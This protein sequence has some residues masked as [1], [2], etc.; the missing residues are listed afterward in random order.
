MPIYKFQVEFS[1]SVT[2]VLLKSLCHNLKTRSTSIQ[3][4]TSIIKLLYLVIRIT[5][6]WRAY[7]MGHH[8]NSCLQYSVV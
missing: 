7:P 3:H 6:R 2:Y 5:G 4:T 8:V 1:K